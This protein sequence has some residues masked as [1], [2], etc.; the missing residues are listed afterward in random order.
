MNAKIW[1]RWLTRLFNQRK[2]RTRLRKRPQSRLNFE[3]LEDRL[4]PTTYTW[5]GLGLSPNWNVAANWQGGVLPTN[6]GDLVFGTLI[7]GASRPTNDNLTTLTTVNSI[8]FSGTGYSNTGALNGLAFTLV[9]G[10][11]VN[12]GVGTETIENQL[13]LT[14]STT[15]LQNTISVGSAATLD[16]AGNLKDVEAAIGPISAAVETAK[17]TLTKTGAGTLELDGN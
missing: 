15:T 13:T 17:V 9:G 4:T 11:T 10:I 14:P 12:G 16:L 2:T 5:V 8:T 3:P 7:P 1:G 6:G